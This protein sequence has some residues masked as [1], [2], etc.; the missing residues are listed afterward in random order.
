MEFYFLQQVC[1]R[2]V[3]QA[4]KT[5]AVVCTPSQVLCPGFPPRPNK[6]S[7]PLRLMDWCY[8]YTKGTEYQLVYR[9]SV[10]HQH[11]LCRSIPIQMISSISR[12]RECAWRIRQ[13]NWY[14]HPL[15]FLNYNSS[16]ISPLMVPDAF[17]SPTNGSC[18]ATKGPV[19]LTPLR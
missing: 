10:G 6:A 14:R 8:T 17:S 18:S 2:L 1:I 4:E 13:T 19:K 15:S 3:A 11:S 12:R 16:L 9:S 5:P 7:I